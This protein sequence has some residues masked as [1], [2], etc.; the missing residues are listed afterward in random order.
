MQTWKLRPVAMSLGAVAAGAAGMTVATGNPG[1]GAIGG[2]ARAVMTHSKRL[3]IRVRARRW[4][5][6][7]PGRAYLL[8]AAREGLL[9]VPRV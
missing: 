1:L 3:L 8:A 2:L 6:T 9:R 7:Q 4:R 5:R